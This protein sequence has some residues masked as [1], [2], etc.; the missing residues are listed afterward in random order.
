M[1][2]ARREIHLHAG[3]DHEGLLSVVI[4]DRLGAARPNGHLHKC[5]FACSAHLHAVDLDPGTSNAVKPTS[6]RT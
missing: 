6:T 1:L 2:V 4:D 3:R 5:A